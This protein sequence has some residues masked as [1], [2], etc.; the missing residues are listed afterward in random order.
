MLEEFRHIAETA[1][2][3]PIQNRMVTADEAQAVLTSFNR[4]TD[5]TLRMNFSDGR[6]T[7]L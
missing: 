4:L 1:V 3:Q 5:D 6:W 2:P 7:T